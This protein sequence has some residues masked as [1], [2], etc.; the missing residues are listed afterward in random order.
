MYFPDAVS[1]VQYGRRLNT[2]SKFAGFSPRVFMRRA[3]SACALVGAALAVVLPVE[4]CV[5]QWRITAQ[6]FVSGF[7]ALCVCILTFASSRWLDG[8]GPLQ[9]NN[10]VNFTLVL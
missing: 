4:F 1:S 9:R 8:F 5:I 7:C 6:R 3:C 2:G 10:N